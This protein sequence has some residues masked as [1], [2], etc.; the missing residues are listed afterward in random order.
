MAHFDIFRDQLAIALP[1]FGHA[2]WEPDHGDLPPVDVGDVGFIRGGKFHRLFNAML[3]ADDPSHESGVPE[4]HEPLKITYAKHI[5]SGTL[6]SN[7]FY[8]QGVTVTSVGL[9]ALV[10]G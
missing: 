3:P 8:S 9:E 7:N 1:A 2:L 10:T 6:P 4:Y 5:D